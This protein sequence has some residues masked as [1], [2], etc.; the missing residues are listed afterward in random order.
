MRPLTSF[1]W[2]VQER[3]AKAVAVEAHIIAHGS[4]TDIAAY[5]GRSDLSAARMRLAWA[6]ALQPRLGAA[7]PASL[8]P[9]DPPGLLRC[10]VRLVPAVVLGRL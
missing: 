7:S 8:G 5:G 6:G 9:C 3:H 1:P 4:A 10:I 2:T